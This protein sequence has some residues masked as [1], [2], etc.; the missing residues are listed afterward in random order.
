L[1]DFAE[2]MALFIK[3]HLKLKSAYFLGHSNGG[4][5]GIYL[6]NKLPEVIKGII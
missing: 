3:E 4:V 2:D 6:A 1:S 5:T